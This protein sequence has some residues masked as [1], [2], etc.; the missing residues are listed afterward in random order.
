MR[1]PP[2]D[3]AGIVMYRLA[4]VAAFAFIWRPDEQ[5]R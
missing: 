3:L 5:W 1:Q 4:I 2:I